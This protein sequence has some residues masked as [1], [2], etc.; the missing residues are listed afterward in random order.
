MSR[1]SL[2]RLAVAYCVIVLAGALW[3]WSKQV[4]SVL[5]LLRIAYG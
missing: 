5:E 1:K 2:Q 3:F 4:Q